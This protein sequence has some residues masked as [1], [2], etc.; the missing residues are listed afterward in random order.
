MKFYF[1]SIFIFFLICRLLLLAAPPYRAQQPDLVEGLEI[2]GSDK[3]SLELIKKQEFVAKLP[4][5]RQAYAAYYDHS[6]PPFVTADCMLS[7][8]Q[9]IYEEGVAALVDANSAK[10]LILIDK[11]ADNSQAGLATLPPPQTRMALEKNA[12][13]FQV[14]AALLADNKPPEQQSDAVKS[15]IALIN[16]A[17]GS[18][19]SPVLG[20]SLDYRRFQIPPELATSQTHSRLF[21]AMVWLDHWELNFGNEMEA[22]QALLLMSEFVADE[23]LSTF[24]AEIDAPADHLYGGSNLLTVARLLPVVK[25]ILGRAP[26][27][28]AELTDLQVATFRRLV[29]RINQNH[30]PFKLLGI[31]SGIEAR[32]WRQLA[33]E[34]KVNSSDAIPATPAGFAIAALFGCARASKL[35]NNRGAGRTG[36][37]LSKAREL[38][39]NWQINNGNTIYS[40]MADCYKALLSPPSDGRL[41]AFTA[42]SAWQDRLLTTALSSWA[43]FHRTSLHPPKGGQLGGSAIKYR[44]KFHGY[45]EP[46]REFF[47]ALLSAANDLRDALAAGHL[48][49]VQLDEF[50]KF[51]EMLERMVEK[52]LAA[53]DFSEKEIDLLE[54]FGERLARLNFIEGNFFDLAQEPDRLITIARPPAE[55]FTVDNSRFLTLYIVVTYRGSRYLCRGAVSTYYEYPVA[56]GAAECDCASGPPPLLP[57]QQSYI[58]VQ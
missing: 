14:G 46:N 27:S 43:G 48:R 44:E 10:L 34:E 21:R 35:I 33:V 19:A 12:A 40:R 49:V 52:E 51:N 8:F 54:N 24:W 45:V 13:I 31:R 36:A 3:A 38:L 6:L 42:S 56:G 53:I 25:Y 17:N 47:A 50:I 4:A 22:R 41:P 7:A 11:L 20:I 39:F 28:I 23:R 32:I 58:L 18:Q 2:L 9:K 26:V 55:A 57:Y 29:A 5:S 30:S 15:E 37:A 16:K 1:K